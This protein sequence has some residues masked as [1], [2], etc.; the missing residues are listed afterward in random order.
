MSRDGY[1]RLY[2]AIMGL[3]IPALPDMGPDDLTPQ[4]TRHTVFYRCLATGQVLTSEH[5]SALSAESFADMLRGTGRVA[6]T[7]ESTL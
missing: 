6:F 1:M 3:D 5:A 4:D 2:R 7:L